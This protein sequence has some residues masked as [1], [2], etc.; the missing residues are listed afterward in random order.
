MNRDAE[1]S[2]HHMLPVLPSTPVLWV[3]L[4][5]ITEGLNCTMGCGGYSKALH[6]RK[7]CS[8]LQPTS[9]S[10]LEHHLHR[11]ERYARAPYGTCCS[12]LILVFVIFPQD[13]FT[14]RTF[15]WISNAYFY[16]KQLLKMNSWYGYFHIVIFKLGPISLCMFHTWLIN[17][18]GTTTTV[19][20]TRFCSCA[21]QLPCYLSIGCLTSMAPFREC[22]AFLNECKAFCVGWGG[23]CGAIA[24]PIKLVQ[25]ENAL[26][27][28]R[29]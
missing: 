17:V 1:N 23:N 10:T 8:H 27:S 20:S 7:V 22:F 3:L 29:K 12:M 6:W 5:N 11:P 13:R 4:V 21:E 25:S 9:Q 16:F 15:L 28:L 24:L 19:T 14:L 2:N 26:R 18:L